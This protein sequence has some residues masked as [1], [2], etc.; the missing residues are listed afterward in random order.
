M[1]E[2]NKDWQFDVECN[3]CG[4]VIYSRYSGELR[5]CSCGAVIIDQT[6]HYQRF[7]GDPKNFKFTMENKNNNDSTE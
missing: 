7:I 3:E 2:R 4:D 6:P 5:S 1:M